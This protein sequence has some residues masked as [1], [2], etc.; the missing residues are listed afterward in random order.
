MP[1]VR[2]AGIAGQVRKGR[3]HASV[4]TVPRTLEPAVEGTIPPKG[5]RAVSGR[6]GIHSRQARRGDGG[7]APG[8]DGENARTPIEEGRECASPKRNAR[9][10]PPRESGI[11]DRPDVADV[12]TLQGPIHPPI[13]VGDS[14]RCPMSAPRWHRVRGMKPQRARLTKA[15]KRVLGLKPGQRAPIQTWLL[16]FKGL[17][18]GEM[19][20]VDWRD[21]QRRGYRVKK[22]VDSALT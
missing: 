12:P 11:V 3:Q 16:K 7:G 21:I 8:G 4:S 1:R 19:H 15:Q 6:D 18:T 17:V 2:K 10:Q 5:G 14:L 9:R 20:W 13:Q 22:K